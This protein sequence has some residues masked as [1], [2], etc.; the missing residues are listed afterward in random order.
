M[1]FFI[2]VILVTLMGINQT[3]CLERCEYCLRFDN[4]T[5]SCEVEAPNSAHFYTFPEE[6]KIYEPIV[7]P[8]ECMLELDHHGSEVLNI[9]VGEFKHGICDPKVSLSILESCHIEEG[10]ALY[11]HQLE[12]TLQNVSNSV[13]SFRF[14][15]NVTLY[16]AFMEPSSSSAKAASRTRHLEQIQGKHLLH[17]TS[18]LEFCRNW[19]ENYTRRSNYT[20]IYCSYDL[21]SS[22]HWPCNQTQARIAYINHTWSIEVVDDSLVS[23]VSYCYLNLKSNDKYLIGDLHQIQ[24]SSYYTTKASMDFVASGSALVILALVISAVLLW[25]RTKKKRLRLIS[26]S[27]TV[28]TKTEE[29]CLI[30]DCTHFPL[31]NFQLG[32]ILGCGQFGEVRRATLIDGSARWDVALKAAKKTEHPV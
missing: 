30:E 5:G 16:Y 21:N 23:V 11:P 29:F 9:T 15:D 8:S 31:Q 24:F 3:F 4:K 18:S 25:R 12:F 19:N 14:K 32:E 20:K 10:D 7:S 22:K 2:I 17:S 26:D 1:S 28:R 13:V 6:S 27:S